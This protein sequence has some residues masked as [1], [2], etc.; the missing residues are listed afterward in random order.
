MRVTD[1]RLT[2]KE[3]EEGEGKKKIEIISIYWYGEGD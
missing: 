2:N 1:V 3:K